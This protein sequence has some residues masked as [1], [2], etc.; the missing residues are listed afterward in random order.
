V[1]EAV[2]EA[3]HDIPPREA[4]W[5]GRSVQRR[6]DVAL[7]RGEARFIDDL[8]P[9][10]G[11]HE[12]AF[13]RSPHAHARIV[14]IDVSAA[15]ALPGVAAVLTG[16]DIAAITNPIPNAI[17]APITYYPMAIDRVRFVG[18]PVAVVVAS[19]RYVAEDALDLI[20]VD[21]EVLPVAA[22]ISAATA[23]GAVAIHDGV[24]GN[25]VHRRSF[26]FGDP[27]AAFAAAH[28][29]VGV[30][31]DYPR[32]MST[33][34]ETYGV[35]ADYTA[36]DGRYTIWSNFQGPFIGHP[37]IAGALRTKTGLVRMVSA[38]A[39]GG[40]FGVKWG[41]FSYA[42]LIAAAARLAAVP[43]KWIEDRA[44]HL[45]A[46]SSSTGRRSRLEGAF[47]RDGRLLGLR[48]NQIENVGAYLRPPEPS[49][50]YRTH[51]NLNGP[52]DVRDIAVDN[53][54]VL[55]N[56]APSGLNR[57]FGGPQYYFPLERLMHE[58]GRELGIDPCD[59]RLR[60]LVTPDAMPYRCAS[61]SL[62]DGG[63][64]PAIVRQAADIA[65]YRDLVR[66]RDEARARGELA[67]IGIAVS[68]ESSAS[69]L[70]YVNAALT[71]E[72]RAKSSDKSGGLAMAS[73]SAD[74]GGQ[75]TLRLP[76]VPAGQGHATVLSQI[77][78]DEL[79]LRPEDIEIVTELDTGLS[80][81]SITSGNYANRFSGADTT[82]AVFAAR[83]VARKLRI[84][85]AAA[86]SC[87]PDDIELRDGLAQVKHRNA[88]IRLKELV[89]W[90]HW[91]SA[92]MPDGLEGGIQETGVFTP[93]RLQSP[94]AEDRVQSSLTTT[95]MCD[96]AAVRVDPGTGR[97]RIVKYAVVHDLGRVLNPALAEGQLR[98]GF[99]HGFGAAMLE[100]LVYDSSG[101][102]LTGTFAD[103]F[104]PVAG[105][106]PP[107]VIGHAAYPTDQN[108]TGARGIGDG[109]SMNP[110]A[111]IANA[112]ADA[113]G[114]ADVSVPATPA[115]LWSL[116]NGLPPDD[117]L[118][119]APADRSERQDGAKGALRGA[120]EQTLP[121]APQTVWQALFAV[122][123]LA[124]IIPG[125]RRLV[126][127]EPDRFE[128]EIVLTVAGLRSTYQ[129]T[130]ALTDKVEPSSLRISGRATGNL[131]FGGGEA[132]IRL[133]PGP[134]DTTRLAYRYQAD[135]GGR[136]AS[137]GH[138]MLDSVVRLLIG[139]FFKGLVRHL[140]PHAGGRGGMSAWMDR[141]RRALRGRS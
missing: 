47:S 105:D 141:I 122:D 57:G 38:P 108:A 97:V 1:T 87:A 3:L 28:R 84:M 88:N 30:E 72:E 49:T 21:Y 99:A 126:E 129:A 35:V 70:A 110:P 8:T 93:T 76:T 29:V 63:D 54:V 45:M 137:V 23:E 7:L 34:I 15:A 130:I 96:I 24:E 121:G 14:G 106:L 42:I 80:D 48:V 16:R 119:H 71:P 40:S 25:V 136:V 115:R 125:C 53:M 109:S 52:Y 2:T 6:E 66:D 19:D 117:H 111:S 68:V 132:E 114:R 127:V 64:Y 59:I 9:F 18:E 74:A 22:D 83:K 102:F 98:G 39:S 94:D 73:L 79:G 95:L 133:T 20:A 131:G 113:L 43:V 92:N 56:Q 50:L 134:D 140:D 138:R 62:L 118:R 32:V 120:G 41:V 86:L 13:L 116:M 77:V 81:W 10:P 4:G 36:A 5:V 65:G 51:G 60:N 100:R 44:E 123:E 46:A 82:A 112:I 104:C 69:S 58:A 37:L 27:D 17:R 67:G 128:A 90:S 85:A 33:P 78:A 124:R 89:G 11:A 75:F 101:N 31:V 12:A 135:V 139:Q 26:R 61:G 91:N 103:Y 107:L 55:T